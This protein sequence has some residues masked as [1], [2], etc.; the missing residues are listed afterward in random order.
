M[1]PADLA[2][3]ADVMIGRRILR[4][5]GE[6][7]EGEDFSIEMDPSAFAAPLAPAPDPFPLAPDNLGEPEKCAC[8]HDRETEHNDAGLCLR[9]CPVSLCDPETVKGKT[10]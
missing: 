4:A 5:S 9:G 3:F 10:P 2:A 6:F 8:N 7:G 1:T